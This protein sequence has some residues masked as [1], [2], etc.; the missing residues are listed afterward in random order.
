MWLNY[1]VARPDHSNESFAV[2]S[3][4]NN[5]GRIQS[6]SDI[7]ATWT[8]VV[9]HAQA[10]LQAQQAPLPDI[11]R[12]YLQRDYGHLH[13]RNI[14]R[15]HRISTEHRMTSALCHHPGEQKIYGDPLWMSRVI[16]LQHSDDVLWSRIWAKYRNPITAQLGRYRIHIDTPHGV[17]R[18]RQLHRA[19]EGRDTRPA[20]TWTMMEQWLA[21]GWGHT[22]IATEGDTMVAYIYAIEYKR[23]AYWMSGKRAEGASLHGLIW[24]AMRHLRDRGVTQLEMGWQ[25]QARDEKGMRVELFKTR[26][27]GVDVPVYG[28]DIYYEAREK[29]IYS[30]GALHPIARLKL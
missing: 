23:K 9:D 10:K 19:V 15:R 16:D 6:A 28:L 26:F 7:I 21:R 18:C 27:G 12:R 5:A 4:H 25:G 1:L 8:V 2:V 11:P 30:G 24:S 14:A 13:L 3:A 22:Y 17:Q 29:R 20:I